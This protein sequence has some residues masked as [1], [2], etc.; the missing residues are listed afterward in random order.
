MKLREDEKSQ[1]QGRSFEQLMFLSEIKYA[2]NLEDYMIRKVDFI[3]YVLMQW[4]QYVTALHSDIVSS[5][6]KYDQYF[7]RGGLN[8]EQFMRLIQDDLKLN[9]VACFGSKKGDH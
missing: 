4:V 1:S 5:F 8:M 7:N 3:E 9:F 6:R 2:R